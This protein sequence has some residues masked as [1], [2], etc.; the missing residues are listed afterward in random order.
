ML[1][2]MYLGYFKFLFDKKS[3]II[4]KNVVLILKRLLRKMNVMGF[5]VFEMENTTLCCF[6]HRNN[7]ETFYCLNRKQLEEY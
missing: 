5:H 1:D 4:S 3:H 2:K 6:F 7:D